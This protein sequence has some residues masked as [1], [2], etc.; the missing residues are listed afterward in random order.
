M[1]TEKKDIAGC[2]V[3]IEDYDICDKCTDKFCHHD[4]EC[5]YL[6]M[7]K[8]NPFTLR[9]IVTSCPHGKGDL[10]NEKRMLLLYLLDNGN[11]KEEIQKELNSITGRE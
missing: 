10:Y 3:H 5:H 7:M 2:S 4:N 9:M 1:R 8:Q 11:T 6:Y